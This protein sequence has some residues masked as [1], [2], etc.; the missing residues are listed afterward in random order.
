[1]P[2]ERLDQ[3]ELEPE[4]SS[5]VPAVDADE[6]F[7]EVPLTVVQTA[8][9]RGHLRHGI[10]GRPG[11]KESQPDGFALTP[12]PRMTDESDAPRAAGPYVPATK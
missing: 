2:V 9:K 11:V 1:V 10:I 7:I 12:S 5:S 3:L 4:Q 6:G 8:S